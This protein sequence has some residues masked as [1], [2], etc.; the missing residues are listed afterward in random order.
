VWNSELYGEKNNT[1]VE[2]LA[3]RVAYGYGLFRARTDKGFLDAWAR[4]MTEA[5][6]T[7]LDHRLNRDPDLV[8]DLILHEAYELAYQ[9]K[10]YRRLAPYMQQ[11]HQARDEKRPP[12]QA[13]F[14]IDV[15]S[16]VF[17]RALEMVCPLAETV[18]FAG[19]FGLPIEYFPIGRTKGG[20]QCPVLLRQAFTICEA[21]EDAPPAEEAR[22]LDLRLLRRR[23][24]K[25]WKAFKLSAVSSFAYVETSGLTY[26]VKIASDSLGLT[27][28]APD[29]N[30]DGLDPDV[31]PRIGPRLEHGQIGNSQSGLAPE[32]HLAV[33]E[34]V[35]KAMSM[36][37]CFASMNPSVSMCSLRRRNPRWK[38]LWKKT[39]AFTHL[40]KMAG[41]I[42]THCIAMGRSIVFT[43]WTTGAT[44]P[45]MVLRT[46][47]SAQQIF[48]LKAQEA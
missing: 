25:A 20:A 33:G 44:Y 45:E 3:I 36:T 6:S 12:I 23:A 7:P 35:L 42:F 15:R 5:A 18:G 28:P 31:I 48:I 17:R 9:N 43:L 10:L 13:A 8:V 47:E 40:L 21:V 30:L 16:E 41:C 29:P 11:A 22:I 27:R 1:L 32:Q 38:A 39:Q 24:L 19:F 4:A 14:C 2:L 37:D 34:A 46:R 26:A